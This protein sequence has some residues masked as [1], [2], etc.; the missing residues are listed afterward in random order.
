MYYCAELFNEKLKFKFDKSSE[1]ERYIMELALLSSI[2][3]YLAIT[4]FCQALLK[5]FL[6]YYG[7]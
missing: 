1:I 6:N 5:L 2:M 7:Y 4:K 3:S